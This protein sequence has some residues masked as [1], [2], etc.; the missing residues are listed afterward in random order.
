[1]T[2][3]IEKINVAT[4]VNMD[5]FNL[6]QKNP[7]VNAIK[8]GEAQPLVSTPTKVNNAESRLLDTT[9]EESVSEIANLITINHAENLLDDSMTD[10]DINA[11]SIDDGCIEK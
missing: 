5:L 10:R 3:E 4:E 7:M 6:E 8:N 2:V 11:L 1:M 9:V